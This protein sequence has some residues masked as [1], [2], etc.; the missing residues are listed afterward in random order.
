MANKKQ[1]W[2][3]VAQISMKE[4]PDLQVEYM[5]YE[6]ESKIIAEIRGRAYVEQMNPGHRVTK[7]KAIPASKRI[8][9]ERRQ[10]AQAALSSGQA[11][12]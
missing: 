4:G 5:N 6:A 12:F 2:D 9:A 3:L 10:A 8:D 11:L 7:I 1:R